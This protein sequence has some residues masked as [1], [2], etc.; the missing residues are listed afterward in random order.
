MTRII[1]GL[2]RGRRL[3]VPPV[4]TRPTSDR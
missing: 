2:A 1:A 3:E 4:V